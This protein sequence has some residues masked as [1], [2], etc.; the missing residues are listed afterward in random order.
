MYLWILWVLAYQWVRLRDGSERDFLR[1][2]GL[3]VALLGVPHF[4][5]WIPVDA[6]FVFGGLVTAS[7]VCEWSLFR[8]AP[9]GSRSPRFLLLAVGSFLAAFAVWLPSRSEG[10]LC[11]PDSFVQGHAIWHLLC[12]GSVWF[13]YCYARSE[14]EG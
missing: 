3:A 10:P 7:I 14:R 13:L 12:A 8:R 4:A 6:N 11:N 1:V 9:A 5:G 2:W